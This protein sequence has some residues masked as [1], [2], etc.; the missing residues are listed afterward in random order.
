M[1]I[2]PF[3]C[4]NSN[5]AD[6]QQIADSLLAQRGDAITTQPGSIIWVETQA[7]ARALYSIW[8]NNQKLAYQFDPN[9]MTAALPRWESI[10]GL[11]ALPTDTIQSRQ[12]R[13]AARFKII[14]KLPNTPNI[15]DLLVDTL[16]ITFLE[17]INI[18]AT[19]AYAQF[20]SGSA[21]TGGITNVVAGPWYST[22]QE[23]FIETIHPP[24][25]TDNEFYAI[26]NQVFPLLNTYLPAYDQFDWFWDSFSD[27]G[28]AGGAPIRATITV[29]VGSTTMTGTG[30]SWKTYINTGDNTYNV[31]PGT[32]IECYD[33]NGNWRRMTV[34]TVNSNTSI[35]LTEPAVGQITAKQYVI[36]GFFLDCDSTQFP[37]PP[38]NSHNMDNAAIN[39]I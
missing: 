11:S 1:A 15:T 28:Y 19:T 21:I 27:D 31:V 12:Q 7:W 24:S 2:L 26:V 39:S 14:N 16:G 18:P 3:R 38:V 32:I 25:L 4:G 9:K 20:P 23:I 33:N 36:Q 29:N 6:L 35:T 34:A 13:I 10:M 8:A 37:Y 30:T 17:L 5:R 22:I